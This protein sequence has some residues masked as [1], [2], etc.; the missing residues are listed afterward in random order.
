MSA[1]TG[2]NLK[3]FFRELA[4]VIGGD[5]K[6]KEEVTSKPQGNSSSNN[7]QPIKA[8]AGTVNLNNAVRTSNEKDKKKC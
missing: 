3:E 8:T 2:H 4:F 7:N 6:S 1:K 5:K